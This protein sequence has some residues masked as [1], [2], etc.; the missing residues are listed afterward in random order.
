MRIGMMISIWFLCWVLGVL[1][2]VYEWG[3]WYMSWY[4][5]VEVG[6]G[7]AEV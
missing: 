6:G 2:S 1:L 5:R 4:L 7:G 3:W